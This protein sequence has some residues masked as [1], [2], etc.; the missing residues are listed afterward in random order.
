MTI[1]HLM[2]GEAPGPRNSGFSGPSGK[3][4]AELMGD[5]WRY[6]VG[7]VNLFDEWPGSAGPKGSEFDATAARGA[8]AMLLKAHPPLPKGGKLM[9]AGRRVARAFGVPAKTQYFE[10]VVL[11]AYG[12]DGTRRAFVA[13]VVPHP[14]GI[15]H[16]WND[17]VN[18]ARARRWFR[19]VK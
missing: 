5:D 16:W 12:V 17:G 2:V 19:R 1:R 14:S 13:C 10:S 15:S 7:V 18:R 3:R 8:A 4:L 11:R 9:L 6:R